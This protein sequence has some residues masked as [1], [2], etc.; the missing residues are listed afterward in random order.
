MFYVCTKVRRGGTKKKVRGGDYLQT[1]HKE[2][3]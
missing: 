2:L 1:Y 3:L